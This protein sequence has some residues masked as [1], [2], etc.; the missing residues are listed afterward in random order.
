M[1]EEVPFCPVEVPPSPSVE[2]DVPPAAALP[3]L[4]PVALVLL[5]VL[6]EPPE[7]TLDAL[8]A[9]AIDPV[10]IA[11]AETRNIVLRYI[12]SPF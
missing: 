1:D 4:P 9:S 10:P 3:P 5:G 11:R 8:C 6:E 2:A 7:P 12:S